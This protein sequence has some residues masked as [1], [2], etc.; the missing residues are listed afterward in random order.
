MTSPSATRQAAP[1]DAARPATKGGGSPLRHWPWALVAV[2]LLALVAV[3]WSATASYPEH[4]G[5][6]AE[7]GCEVA[8]GHRVLA[9][10]GGMAAAGLALAAGLIAC[11][12]SR[13]CLLYTTDAAD[14]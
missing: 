10:W 5:S 6:C 1:A 11:L 9:H 14:E 13:S 8:A 4:A 7:P 2:A 12:R 3:G